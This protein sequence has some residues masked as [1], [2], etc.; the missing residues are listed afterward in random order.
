MDKAQLEEKKS[1][2]EKE[3]AALTIKYGFSA[4][5]EQQQK[6]IEIGKELEEVTELLCHT[7][8]T[9]KIQDDKTGR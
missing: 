6:V 4:T 2:L 5:K 7:T 8:P 9:V 1:A 3:L